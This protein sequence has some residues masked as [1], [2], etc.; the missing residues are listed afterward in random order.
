LKDTS[1][2]NAVL[3]GKDAKAQLALLAAAR[4]LRTALPVDLVAPLLANKMLAEVAESYLIVEDSTAARRL[5]WARHP[6]E[7][8]ILGEKE[9]R[10]GFKLGNPAML[11]AREKDAQQALKDGVAEELYAFYGYVQENLNAEIRLRRGRAQLRLFT[12]PNVWRLRDLSN[13]ELIELQTLVARPEVAELK[14]ETPLGEYHYGFAEFVRVSKD[15]GYRVVLEGMK[16]MPANATLHEQLSDLFYRFSKTG[17][18]ETH[19][20][21]EAKLPGVEVLFADE[22]QHVYA[23][24]REGGDT[25]V[26]AGEALKPR[27]DLKGGPHWQL[28]KDGQ[29]GSTVSAPEIFRDLEFLSA[30]NFLP[31]F[32]LR[33]DDSDPGF[34]LIMFRQM[35]E[36]AKARNLEEMRNSFVPGNYVFS[37]TATNQKWRIGVKWG[38][39]NDGRLMRINLQT[40]QE[41]E[42]G[43]ENKRQFIPLRYLDGTNKFLLSSEAPSGEFYLL[44]PASGALQPAK[45]EFRPLQDQSLRT[46]QPTSKPN[47][48]WAV[49]RENEQGSRLGR[50]DERT[51]TFKSVL[52]VPGL[53]LRSAD[54]WVDE[55]RGK[56]WLTY[57]GH[58]LRLPLPAAGK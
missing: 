22:K 3:Q 53:S 11:V 54:V 16:P 27:V 52:E 12:D 38:S 26:L 20:A 48:F 47:E 58:L 7:A 33:L 46:L 13:S 32:A 56:V 40:G 18:Y 31:Q 39:Q 51:F 10:T 45:G 42:V 9:P 2:Q 24:C 17:T 4:Y 6:G 29:L 8:L 23:V 41:F 49:I 19:Y 14:P 50:Y 35:M 36:Q 28:F 21:I 57:H 34:P 37:L 30:G 44:D 5:V 1:L 55:T 15:G 25:L 43:A